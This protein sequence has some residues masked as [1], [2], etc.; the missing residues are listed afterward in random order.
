[1]LQ[2][3]KSFLESNNLT[4]LDLSKLKNIDMM[5]TGPG[6]IFYKAMD[7]EQVQ[8]ILKIW[9]DIKCPLS[10]TDLMKEYFE[11]GYIFYFYVT[12]HKLDFLFFEC[13]AESVLKVVYDVKYDYI[14]FEDIP[15]HIKAIVKPFISIEEG[16]KKTWHGI[17]D[18]F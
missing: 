6:Y 12:R 7:V 4:P 1:M 17:Y 15:E 9:P 8:E 5:C 3:F 14:K 16:Y 10:D 13:D 11:F 18:V 2:R